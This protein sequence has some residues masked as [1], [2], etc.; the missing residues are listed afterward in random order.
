M[1]MRAAGGQLL[2]YTQ[3]P[4][5]S[6]YTAADVF[7]IVIPAGVV[8]RAANGSTAPVAFDSTGAGNA[9]IFELKD[10]AGIVGAYQAS[11]INLALYGGTI[12]VKVSSSSGGSAIDAKCIGVKFSNCKTGLLVSGTQGTIDML[13]EDCIILDFNS[14]AAPS[15]LPI[16]DVG[17]S[18]Q[19][20][21]TG[22][23]DAE[24][25]NLTTFGDFD[26]TESQPK[27]RLVEVL[28]SGDFPEH[29]SSG[30]PPIPEVFLSIDAG[31]LD[32]QRKNGGWKTGV[33]A[34]S[35]RSGGTILLDYAAGYQVS[36]AG[37]KIHKF[38]KNGVEATTSED[39]RGQL[40]LSGAEIY[41]NEIPSGN[42]PAA[43]S[44]V[45]VYCH[46]SN[47]YLM[48]KGDSAQVY[49]NGT[50]GIMLVNQM[51]TQGEQSAF[52]LHKLPEGL[53]LDLEGCEI[54]GNNIDGIFAQ[55]GGSTGGLT[56]G[57][58]CGTRYYDS[59][60]L[61][62]RYRYFES[63]YPEFPSGQGRI[64]R[65]EIHNNG[66]RGIHTKLQESG[67]AS[68]RLVRSVLWNNYWEGWYA[69]ITNQENIL[70]APIVF[71]T[72]AGNGENSQANAN[73]EIAR[74]SNVTPKYGLDYDVPSSKRLQTKFFHTVFARKDHASMSSNMSP[75]FGPQ[76][77]GMEATGDFV[78]NTSN[79]QPHSWKVM[80]LGCRAMEDFFN[81]PTQ[82]Q[83]SHKGQWNS[84]DWLVTNNL[85][86]YSPASFRGTV[87]GGLPPTMD[88][89]SNDSAQFRLINSVE[90]YG[91][92]D[93]NHWDVENLLMGWT[94]N[95]LSDIHI[96][97]M[98]FETDVLGG[99]MQTPE[100]T[101]DPIFSGTLWNLGLAFE[102]NKGAFFK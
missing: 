32:G 83:D 16:P 71:C 94:V 75:D 98:D 3:S 97:T 15:N 70:A 96:S 93:G 64:V 36:L 29:S 21:G 54:S 91:G 8:V 69:H 51:A 63:P 73:I 45:G 19:A 9:T 99:N 4:N 48:L 80:A 42:Q 81:V 46:N 67:I 57:V 72:L 59:D 79:T 41:D 38:S 37:V 44:G 5:S 20:S 58:V 35:F 23:I 43:P 88:W 34:S 84:G 27:S 62:L 22:L 86:Y 14:P 77:T 7:P 56:D 10:S 11:L 47:G 92:D 76:L 60:P 50:H 53:F 101:L 6:T 90:L 61:E 13:V 18:F 31:D 65:S 17:L 26:S 1:G 28:A 78:L 55:G 85:G 49:N 87:L 39:A 33:F 40:T 25:V 12:G 30:S 66:Q 2:P 24:V 74:D 52:L 95:W 100:Y 68:F 102:A 82:S 89:Q